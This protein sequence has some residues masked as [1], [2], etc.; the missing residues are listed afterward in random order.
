M[1][2]I[3]FYIEPWIELNIPFWKRDYIWWFKNNIESAFKSNTKTESL[4]IIN[5]GIEA[6]ADTS[7]IENYEVIYQH[8]LI[9]IFSSSILSL[10]NWQNN[11][12]SET[13]MNAMMKLLKLKLKSFEPD[14][15]FTISPVPYL[16]RLFPKAKIFSKE[17]S[18]KNILRKIWKSTKKN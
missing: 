10:K 17:S 8:E 11:T 6:S 14:L 4:F 15:I 3:L 13:E 12:F 9:K 1:K 5:E 2:K 7:I 16:S 18:L